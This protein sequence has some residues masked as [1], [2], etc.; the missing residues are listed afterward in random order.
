VEKKDRFLFGR[1]LTGRGGKRG[2]T[3]RTRGRSA[4]GLSDSHSFR[5][6]GPRQLSKKGKKGGKK[7]RINNNNG[8]KREGEGG[9]EGAKCT[10]E[11]PA[12]L[13]AW[14]VRHP[15]A[16]EKKKK[17]EENSGTSNRD[18][19]KKKRRKRDRDGTIRKIFPLLT[20]GRSEKRGRGKRKRI[21]LRERGENGG[22]HLLFRS[23]SREGKERRGRN[24][25]RH[26]R[27]RKK[28]R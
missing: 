17:K 7:E 1:I 28:G 10:D 15:V 14:R 21:K 8:R 19:T 12:I 5:L 16:G 26:V 27:K 22:E 4:T 3:R 2:S 18:L 6:P 20:R 9:K 23:A 25:P 13:K 11:A 24:E